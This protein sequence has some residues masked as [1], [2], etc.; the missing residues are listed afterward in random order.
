LLP[1]GLTFLVGSPKIGKSWL[2]LDTA[3][4]VALGGK[5][6]G[7]ID[8]DQGAVLYF[9]L[10]DNKRRMQK[11]IRALLGK[12]HFPEAL[13]ITHRCPPLGA[14]LEQEIT[15]WLTAT[16]STRLVIVDTLARVRKQRRRNGDKYQ[17]DADTIAKLQ[18]LATNHNVAILVVHHDRKA[19]AEDVLATISGTFG[20]SG[21][22]DGAL[23]LKRSRGEA[24][25]TLFVTGRDIENEQE[26]ALRF[27]HGAWLL[28]GDAKE[29][30]ITKERQD[31]LSLL[32]PGNKALP[33]REIAEALGKNNGA[34]RRL[35]AKMVEDGQVK[36]N[37]RGRYFI[38][39]IQNG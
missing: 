23:M 35:L 31:I 6:L 5:A 32:K 17:E 1:E 21:S 2:A 8:V 16:P 19:E 11:R 25:A 18:T 24:D 20:L 10:E 15:S 38:P 13:T 9:A 7:S 34:I 30:A 36:V 39:I 26:L 14:G 29:Y 37:D 22:A 4:A 3:L 12:Q 27:L 33:P 28:M